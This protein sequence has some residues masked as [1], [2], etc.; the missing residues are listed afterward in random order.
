MLRICLGLLSGLLLTHTL[1]AGE[2]D[3]RAELIGGTLPEF[4]AKSTAQVDLGNINALVLHSGHEEVVIPYG[5]VNSLEYGQNVSQR[6]VVAILVSPVPLL[7]KSHFVT[8]GYT[9]NEGREKALVFRVNKGDIGPVLAVL[10][11]RTRRRVEY[12]P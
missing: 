12:Q 2:P 3:F 6:L 5:K 1:P 7:S 8:V 10:E 4:A 9:D 11:A